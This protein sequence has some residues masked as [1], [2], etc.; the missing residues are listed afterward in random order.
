MCLA[1]SSEDACDN[2][3]ENMAYVED[4]PN[5]CW[6]M[7]AANHIPCANCGIERIYHREKENQRV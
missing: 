3:A 4:S 5:M 6:G 7:G 2:Y 1:P